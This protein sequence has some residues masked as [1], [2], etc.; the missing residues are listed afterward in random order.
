M[1][2]WQVSVPLE[3]RG[4]GGTNGEGQGAG[5]ESQSARPA[6]GDRSV[7]GGKRRRQST[8]PVEF[9]SRGGL[10]AGGKTRPGFSL[11]DRVSLCSRP[12][13]GKSGPRR[14]PGLDFQQLLKL[15]RKPAPGLS[16]EGPEARSRPR[17]L[18]LRPEH[19]EHPDMDRRRS[20]RTSRGASPK[21][22]SKKKT[23]RQSHSKQLNKKPWHLSGKLPFPEDL[24]LSIIGKVK[25]TEQD[26]EFGDSFA[27]PLHS[28]ALYSEAEE[29]CRP[30]ESLIPSFV[31][32][33]PGKKART[34]A[35]V[36][37]NQ[38]EE[39]EGSVIGR[40]KKASRKS[41]PIADDTD[42]ESISG[43]ITCVVKRM[44]KE[45]IK[46]SP[47]VA[48]A[49][50][51]EKSAE[52]VSSNELFH[53]A[54]KTS[55]VTE[56][57]AKAPRKRRTSRRKREK[58]QSQPL[59]SVI[60]QTLYIWSPEK[61]KRSARDTAKSHIVLSA[62]EDAL[63]EYKQQVESIICQK[64]VDSFYSIFK[65]QLIKILS[66][67]QKLKNLK[68]KNA[69]VITDI[70]KKRKCL[71]EAQNQLIRTEPKLKHLQIKYEELKERK[72]SLTEATWFLS[73]LKQLHHDYAALKRKTPTERE[74]YDLS[75]LPALLFE[76]RGISGA[77][78]HL[79]KINCHLQ[80]LVDHK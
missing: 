22:E 18:Q 28:T 54:E 21:K 8:Q 78:Q 76:A 80:Q 27:A 11:K 46:V 71:F 5:P 32:P 19:F 31:S 70:N 23:G 36:T 34:S 12:R 60:S 51:P 41:K 42:S 37:E 74:K 72:S 3:P 13:G 48:S 39:E 52:P 50:L 10:R 67:V 16:A 57:E 1:Y 61:K 20:R 26:E 47:T 56:S 17:R 4:A 29:I 73:N 64:A 53:V 6:C 65:E 9:E 68:R 38:P 2:D 59:N 63:L 62:F 79:K 45:R 75:S 77:A 33:P 49:N 14:N 43:R 44:R 58:P 40:A 7:A 25:E 35:E 24:D 30:A 69:K 15:R 55:L 66:E